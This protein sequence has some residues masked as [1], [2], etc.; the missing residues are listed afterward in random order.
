MSELGNE[1]VKAARLRL[2]KP[3]RHHYEPDLC[4]GGKITTDT[5]MENGMDNR[6]YDCS[7]LVIASFCE[8][9]GIKPEQWPQELR[10][11]RQLDPHQVGGSCRPGDVLLYFGTEFSRAHTSIAILGGRAIHASGKSKRVEEVS[12]I[13]SDKN[14]FA[15]ACAIPAERI[16]SLG[17]VQ[18]VARS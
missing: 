2:G 1:V 17:D 14:Y 10:H 18:R 3:F 4:G 7:G 6:G 8:V 11:V 12:G 13:V 9:Y 16:I 5:C 15:R